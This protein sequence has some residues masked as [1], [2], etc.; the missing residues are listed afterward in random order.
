MVIRLRGFPPP[1]WVQSACRHRRRGLIVAP[2]SRLERRDSRCRSAKAP[3]EL[4]CSALEPPAICDEAC[5][6]GAGKPRPRS[7]FGSRRSPPRQPPEGSI[8]ADRQRSSSR[9][10]SNSHKSQR[11][12]AYRP[13]DPRPRQDPRVLRGRAGFQAGWRRHDNDRRRR[14]PAAY[15]FR[16][17]RRSA[18]CLSGRRG[19]I[20]AKPAKMLPCC[21]SRQVGGVSPD[22]ALPLLRCP[23]D[24]ALMIAYKV[25]ASSRTRFAG[26][27]GTV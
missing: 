16:C 17:R 3:K 23:C 4:K 15:V 6:K 11:I 13:L 19:G 26:A 22:D 1:A 12:F 9:P 8:D 27:P 5:S 10:R 21:N 25:M 14:S 7:N 24:H 18:Y 2:Q 20:P